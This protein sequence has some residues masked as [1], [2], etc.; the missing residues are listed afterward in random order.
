MAGYP[1]EPRYILT[2]FVT[3]I[4]ACALIMQCDVLAI[5]CM[6]VVCCHCMQG[7]CKQKLEVEVGD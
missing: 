7:T 3:R 2:N 5:S 1:A 6:C 4:E